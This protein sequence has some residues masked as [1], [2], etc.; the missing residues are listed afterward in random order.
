MSG[1]F[2]FQWPGKKAAAPSGWTIPAKIYV[3]FW[4]G[5]LSD[6]KHYIEGLP[7]GFEYS[8]ELRNADKLRSSAPSGIF[9]AEKHV[10]FLKTSPIKLTNISSF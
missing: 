7:Q 5:V 10:S 8:S 6:K 1:F 3:Y 4:L 2:K 9:Y